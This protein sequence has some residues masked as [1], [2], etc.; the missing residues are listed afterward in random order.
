[1][2]VLPTN[3]RTLKDIIHIIIQNMLYCCNVH[4]LTDYEP[5]K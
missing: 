2:V 1:M 4:A 5:S 3:F